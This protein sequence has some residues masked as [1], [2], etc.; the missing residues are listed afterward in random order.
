MDLN[1]GRQ[2]ELIKRRMRRSWRWVTVKDDLIRI[3]PQPP[4]HILA[5]SRWGKSPSIPP[6]FMC[7]HI[8]PTTESCV[9]LCV[10]VVC[11]RPL[12]S[13]TQSKAERRSARL[14]LKLQSESELRSLSFG[15]SLGIPGF[16]KVSLQHSW[17][18]WHL[19][20]GFILQLFLPAILWS[21]PLFGVW[22]LAYRIPVFGKTFVF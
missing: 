5:F 1:G 11:T 14:L 4:T 17:E 15:L 18:V 7:C 13:D 22:F 6:L 9:S 20:Q 16:G 2:E 19:E 3:H 8:P 12:L 10:C 21:I